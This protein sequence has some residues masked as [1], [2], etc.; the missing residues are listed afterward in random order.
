MLIELVSDAVQVTDLAWPVS[1]AATGQSE[2][3][4]LCASQR[5]GCNQR[6]LSCNEHLDT[7]KNHK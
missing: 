1:Y 7:R 2:G 4:Q 6:L 5:A 3:S